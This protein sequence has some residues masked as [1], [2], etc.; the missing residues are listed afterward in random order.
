MEKEFENFVETAKEVCRKIEHFNLH[1]TDSLQFALIK[2]LNDASNLAQCSIEADDVEIEGKVVVPK[3]ICDISEDL[4]FHV[5]FDP[6]D[7]KSACSLT[8]KN[9][10]SDIYKE[11][12]LGCQILENEPRKKQSVFWQWQFGYKFHWGRHLID[13]IRFFFLRNSP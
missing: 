10:L 13:V 9:A 4:F 7:S 1:D 3:A 5:F 8:L 12:K 2:L 11:L 6:S